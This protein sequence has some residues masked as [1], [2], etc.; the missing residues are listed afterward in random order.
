[1]NPYNNFDF[2]PA[3]KLLKQALKEDKGSGDITSSILIPESS[4]SIAEIRV[5]QNCVISGLEI[6]RRVFRIV[7]KN[8]KVEF[9]ANDGSLVEKGKIIGIVSGNTRSILL[10]ERLSLNIIQRMSGIST[11]THKLVKSLGN[12]NIKIIDTRKTTPNFRMFEKLAVRI[13]GG[14]NHRYGLFD[15][16][17]VKDNHI[18]ANGG[19]AP[20]LK[21]LKRIKQRVRVPIEVEVKDL[22]ELAI[23]LTEGAG[24]VNRVMLDNFKI[25][26]VRKAVKM[27]KGQFELEISG[28]INS[29]SISRYRNIDGIDYI[30]VGALTHSAGSVD[31]SLDFIT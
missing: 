29:K 18:E 26:D 3:E 4:R 1:M 5:K 19:I 2:N 10:A 23:V 27:C 31:I 30:S 6:F 24:V 7:D 25:P 20:T 15:M 9:Y 17:L 21:R 16:M 28:G 12:S 22:S 14:D 11:L 13:G 8:V